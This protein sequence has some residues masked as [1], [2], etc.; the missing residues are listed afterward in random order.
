MVINEQQASGGQ[1]SY[2]VKEMVAK[3]DASAGNMLYY[4]NHILNGE[5]P[6]AVA[7]HNLAEVKQK[8][9]LDDGSTAYIREVLSVLDESG[10]KPG[11]L[12]EELLLTIELGNSPGTPFSEHEDDEPSDRW[13]YQLFCK[14]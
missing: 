1:V 6:F 8:G 3:W 2:I 9:N 4:F 10:T 13:I 14:P 12:P 7:A 11:L 5:R